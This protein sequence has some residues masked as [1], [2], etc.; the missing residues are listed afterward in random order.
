M[1]TFD[2]LIDAVLGLP[3]HDRA[4]R[5]RHVLRRSRRSHTTQLPF[6]FLVFNFYLSSILLTSPC[7]L[8]NLVEA[9]HQLYKLS[10]N[11]LVDR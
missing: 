4:R 1:P 11:G 6:I 7:V 3:R 8:H 5:L 2:S 10:C 9:I